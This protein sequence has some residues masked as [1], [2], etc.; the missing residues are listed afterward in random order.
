MTSIGEKRRRTFYKEGVLE[1]SHL[2]VVNASE[3]D[4]FFF[5]LQKSEK[6][7]HTDTHP[8]KKEKYVWRSFVV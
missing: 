7:L 5:L 2:P 3:R 6:E 8:K 4:C 1:I